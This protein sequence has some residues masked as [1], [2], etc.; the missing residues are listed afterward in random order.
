[1][2]AA[3]AQAI[4][5]VRLAEQHRA[6]FLHEE[7]ANYAQQ[8]IRD[9]GW[10][11]SEALD[12]A[13]AALLPVLERELAEAARQ[14]HALWSAVTA[15]GVAVGWLWVRPSGTRARSAFLYQITVAKSFRRRGYGRA[16]LAALEERLVRDGVDELL[17]HVNVGNLPARRLYAAAGYEQVEEDQRVCRL[18]KRLGGAL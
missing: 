12:R 1:M 15:D 3:G 2:S 6:A 4:T 11:R 5:L 13:R 9:A 8:Q 7:V 16:M 18:R 17:L 14:G 10:P